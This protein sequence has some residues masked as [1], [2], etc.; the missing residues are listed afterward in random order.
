ML[1][2]TWLPSRFKHWQKHHAG[3]HISAAANHVLNQPSCD[4]KQEDTTSITSFFQHLDS[5]QCH[6]LRTLLS[7]HLTSSIRSEDHLTSISASYD[8]GTC[9]SVSAHP[10]NSHTSWLV[11]SGASEIFAQMRLNLY[12]WDLL[13]IPLSSAKPYVHSCSLLWWYQAQSSFNPSWC[14]ICTSIPIQFAICECSIYGISAC[15]DLFP[16]PF[17]YPGHSTPKDDWQG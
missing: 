15:F 6:K 8:I 14:L 1:Q 2:I 10:L 4:T 13:S 3:N 12:L 11:D 5:N 17:L 16:W 9:L 7:N